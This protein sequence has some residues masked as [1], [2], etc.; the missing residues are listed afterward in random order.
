MRNFQQMVQ[1]SH[2]ASQGIWTKSCE[3]Y[4]RRITGSPSMFTHSCTAALEICALLCNLGPADEVILPTFTFVS[5]ANAFALRS[6]QIRFADSMSQHP[7][8]SIDQILPLITKKTKAIVVVHYAGLAVDMDA[9]ADLCQAHEIFLIEDAA[10]AVGSQYHGKPLGSLG[11]FACFSFHDTKPISCGEGGMLVLNRPDCIDAAEMILEK[12]T[13]RLK[14]LR[15]SIPSY[16]WKSLGSSYA[17][18]Q[19]Q[20]CILSAQLEEIKT[21]MDYRKSLFNTYLEN[22]K[23]LPELFILPKNQQNG[24][25]NGSIFFIKTPSI[26]VQKKLMAFLQDHHIECSSHY[27]ALHRSSYGSAHYPSNCPE[28]EKWED[29]IIRLPIHNNLSLDQINHVSEK[30]HRWVKANF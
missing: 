3:D 2:Y 22:L 29:Q 12:G 15:S 20:G 1:Q 4:F 25:H 14:F 9:I 23:G 30:I 21:I 19:L 7:N 11:D 6:A 27:K 13:D 5:T 16:T 10:H 24:D 18:S 17:A 28:A 8:I 26:D